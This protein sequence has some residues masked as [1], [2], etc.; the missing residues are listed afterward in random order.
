MHLSRI[1]VS[2]SSNVNKFNPDLFP[3]LL[4]EEI[5][6]RDSRLDSLVTAVPLPGMTGSIGH[7]I[8]RPLVLNSLRKSQ[9]HSD[10]V[11]CGFSAVGSTEKMKHCRGHKA[12]EGDIWLVATI[13][14]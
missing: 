10:I 13:F 3:L 8:S 1:S 14:S 11:V 12:Q 9:Q 6:N 2:I 4:M 7:E 5:E